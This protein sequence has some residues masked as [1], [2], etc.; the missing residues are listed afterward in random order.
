MISDVDV[1][2]LRNP[3]PYFEQYP[4][5]D[6]LTSSDHLTNTVPGYELEKFQEAGSAANIGA[7]LSCGRRKLG[8]CVGVGEAAREDGTEWP[9]AASIGARGW[10]G[11]M[12]A[13]E[14]WHPPD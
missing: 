4:D 13:E 9:P 8:A 14:R 6:V 1:L 7:H 10:G 3:I 2:W 5:A 12:P 11:G